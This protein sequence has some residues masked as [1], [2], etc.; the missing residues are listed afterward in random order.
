MN[1]ALKTRRDTYYKLNTHL[2]HVDNEQL[3]SLFDDVDKTGGRGT[4]SIIKLGKSKVFVKRIPVTEIEYNH[5]FS[6]K[7]LYSLPTYYNYGVGS[8]GF[9]V[10]RELVTHIKTTNWVLEGSIENFPLMYDYRIVP[11]SGKNAEM[12]M[13]EHTEYVEYWNSNK[14]IGKYIIDRINAKYETV[15]FLEYIPYML[16]SWFGT[17]AVYHALPRG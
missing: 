12:D 8:A 9:G 10:F 7:N 13:K 11:R 4:N 15:L 1:D 16:W 17:R 2:A 6:T 3:N 5:M 14:N